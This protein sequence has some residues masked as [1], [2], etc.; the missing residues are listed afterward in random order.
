MASFLEKETRDTWNIS[1]REV[2]VQVYDYDGLVK[3]NAM[4]FLG[5]LGFSIIFGTMLS[6]LGEEGKPMTIWF[7]CLFNVT[8]KMIEIFMW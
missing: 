5:I 6:M 1:G 3:Y 2:T 7:N 8:M 4:N